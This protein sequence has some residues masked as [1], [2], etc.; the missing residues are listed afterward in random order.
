MTT[1]TRIFS[2]NLEN[3]SSRL[4]VSFEKAIAEA[5]VNSL[6]AKANNI[7]VNIKTFQDGN[8]EYVEVIDDGEGFTDFN[9]N[10][11]FDLHSDYKKCIGGKGV[12]RATWFKF[13]SIISV[14]SIFKIN[15][16]YKHVAFTFKKNDREVNIDKKTI[17]NLYTKTSI[18][19]FI[20]I[21]RQVLQNLQ[22]TLKSYLLK[23]MALMLYRL[24]RQ[25]IIRLNFIESDGSCTNQIIDQSDLPVNIKK[26]DFDV[27][28]EKEN[29]KFSLHCI[30]FETKSGNKVE[31]GFVAGD[32]TLSSFEAALGLKVKSPTTQY[33]GQ[34][35]LLLES[36]LL[37]EGKFTSDD[38]ETVI[39]PEGQDLWGNDVRTEIRGKLSAAISMETLI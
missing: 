7:E 22:H 17:D 2:A 33:S 15:N 25:F 30:H 27:K 35:W 37:T 13:F 31:T 24:E 36:Q 32:R 19:M 18:K 6:Q 9:I 23:E 21:A 26:Y 29:K 10:S 14:D 3:Y 28:I 38:R 39:F 8:I 1:E 5:V 20:Y 16:K 12:G 34:Y 11:F 4:N